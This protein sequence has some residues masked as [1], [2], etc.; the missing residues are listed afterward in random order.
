MKKQIL[1]KMAESQG[2]AQHSPGAPE[3]RGEPKELKMAESQGFE[4]WVQFPVHYLS[5]VARSTTPATL[6]KILI[7]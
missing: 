4:P 1:K 5:K 6:R 7:N 3:I 2:F